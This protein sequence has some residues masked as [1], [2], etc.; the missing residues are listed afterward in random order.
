MD[1]G[2]VLTVGITGRTP[3][4]TDTFETRAYDAAGNRSTPALTADVT[5]AAAAAGTITFPAVKDWS[6]GNLKL[7]ES[8]VTVIVNNP[9]TGA[10]VVKL[11][12]KTTHA[13]T[14]VCVVSDA[15]IIAGTQYRA[16]MILADGS[17]GTWKYTAT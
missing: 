2:N 9:T 8:G 14:G 15:A 11:T 13:T 5:L 10:L 6:T 4:S 3:G 12:G 7:N 17:E 16:T 1:A